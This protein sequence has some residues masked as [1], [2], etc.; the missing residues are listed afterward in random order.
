MVNKGL[1]KSNFSAFKCLKYTIEYLVRDKGGKVMRFC[2]DMINKTITEGACP[3]SMPARMKPLDEKDVGKY[4]AM[5]YKM[6]STSVTMPMR[7]GM[8]NLSSS[9]VIIVTK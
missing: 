2:I 1:Y 6:I 5:G 9:N 3:G 4:L 7:R 8:R